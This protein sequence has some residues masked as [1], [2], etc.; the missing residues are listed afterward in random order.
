MVMSRF[1][2]LPGRRE[3]IA[4]AASSAALCLTRDRAS[5]QDATRVDVAADYDA[6]GR[7]IPADFI[8]LSY[9]SAIL[10]TR[11]FSPGNRSVV[12]LL[13]TLGTTGVLRIGGNSSDRSVWQGGAKD[14]PLGDIYV[15]TP[16]IIDDL[17]AFLRAVGWRLIYGLDLGN[18]TPQD[19]AEEA[20]YV[21]RAVGPQLLAFQI[22]NEPDGFG[23]WSGLRAPSYEVSAFIAEW[24]AFVDAVR[25]RVPDAPFAGPAVASKAQ[26]IAPFADACRD[27]LVLLTRHYYADGPARAPHVSVARLLGSASQVA[28]ILDGVRAIAGRHGLPYRISET[29]SIFSEGHPGV[30]DTL[31]A[32]LWGLEFMFQV[33]EAGGAGVNFHAGDHKFY[34][35]IGLNVGERR[36]AQPLYYGI[37]MFREASRG[38][39]VPTHV[40]PPTDGV[41]AH[42]VRADDGTL[43]V[44]VINRDLARHVRVRVDSGRQVG[45]A[46]SL[47]LAG[48]TPD[49]RDVILG[50]A[51]VSDFGAWTP[52]ANEAVQREGRLVAVALPPASAMLVTMTAA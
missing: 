28:P 44:C 4:G 51:T 35:P 31:A 45:P 2:A 17:A 20:A 18:G 41:S 5:A 8:G 24:Q 7:P 48:E 14:L 27:R 16:A 47:R 42:T 50:G 13:R 19:A 32:A 1:A 21:A 6:P 15:I 10:A 49:A 38:A 37:L 43:R 23:T 46:S 26:W 39:L 3:I 36:R 12:G 30:S 29:N 25:R 9:E 11:Y 22:G 33:A 52:L 40:V 34:T